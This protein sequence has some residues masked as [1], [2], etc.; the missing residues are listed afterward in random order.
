MKTAFFDVDTQLDF[1]FP[2]GALYARGAERI[3]ENLERLSRFAAANG[4]RVISSAD[5][6]AQNDAEFLH[7]PPHCVTGTMGQ[8]KAQGTLLARRAVM[9]SKAPLR[10]WPE[11]VQQVVVEKQ[12]IDAFD[13]RG[14]PGLIEAV[15]AD[16]FVVYG[17]VTEVCVKCAA[18]GL[19]KAGKKVGLV[20]DAV[21]HLDEVA[22]GAV[23][24]EF[25]GMGG[26]PTT[27][28]EICG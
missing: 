18:W 9:T 17:V 11:G 27:T 13:N 4:V 2:A 1:L 3:V 8:M 21:R 23:L 22:A 24:R 16:R 28:A 15:E 7:W 20:S 6:H 19:L 10:V 5:A 12:T 14:L 26:T 25:E